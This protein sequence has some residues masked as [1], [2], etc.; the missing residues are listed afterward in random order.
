MPMPG[1]ALAALQRFMASDSPAAAADA[2]LDADAD[3]NEGN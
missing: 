2:P 1:P 3:T